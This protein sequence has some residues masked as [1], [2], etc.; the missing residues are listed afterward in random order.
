M[1]FV[2]AEAVKLVQV[3]LVELTM[4]QLTVFVAYR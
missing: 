2:L 3:K 4:R 1:P